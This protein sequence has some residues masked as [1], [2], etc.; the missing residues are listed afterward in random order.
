MDR[1]HHEASR[2]QLTNDL[3]ADVDSKRSKP[4]VHVD[5]LR[6]MAGKGSWVANA[7]LALRNF[8]QPL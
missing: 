6:R 8:L 1:R 3:K 5:D 4:L 7:G 2:R